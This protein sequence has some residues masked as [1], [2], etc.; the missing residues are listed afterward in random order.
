[1][2]RNYGTVSPLFL[3]YEYPEFDVDKFLDRAGAVAELFE[4][5]FA[6]LVP[7]NYFMQR[8]I[9]HIVDH[10]YSLDTYV[11]QSAFSFYDMPENVAWS[12][13]IANDV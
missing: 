13:P 1:M 4:T 8:A 2:F 6:A 3:N 5:I 7:A 12:A 10:R 9:N 11:S